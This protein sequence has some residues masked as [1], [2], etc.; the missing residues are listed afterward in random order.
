MQLGQ[1]KPR[2][3]RRRISHYLHLL[4][5]SLSSR[6][7]SKGEYTYGWTQ[8]VQKYNDIQGIITR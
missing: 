4:S 2:T 6:G 8:E 7:N 5:S 1:R 3:L